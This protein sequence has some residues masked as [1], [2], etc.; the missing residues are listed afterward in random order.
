MT[1]IDPAYPFELGGWTRPV[2]TT[3]PDAQTWFDR[4]LNWLFAYNHEEAVACFGRALDADPGCAM[5]W[6][7]IAYASGPFYNRAWIRFSDA[8]IA[9]TLPVCH[10]AALKAAELWAPGTAAERALIE[11]VALRYQSPSERDRAVLNRWHREFT[12]AMRQVHAAHPDDLDIAALF[13]EAAVT[14]TPRM[15]FDLRTGAPNPASLTVEALAVLET[16]LARCAR[17]GI[18]HPGVLHMHIHALEMSAEP[19]RALASADTLRGLAPDAGHLE[20]MPAH[21]YVLCGGYSEA[22]EQSRR[23]VAAD[24]KYLAVGGETNFYTTARCHDLH[25]YI[26]AAML[27]GQYRT[28]LHAAEKI[29]AIAHRDLLAA[30]APFMR[31]ILDGYSGMRSHVQVR[32]GKWREL[33]REAPPP[34]PDLAPIRT[35][36]FHYA[37]GVA[38]AALGELD[39]AVREADAFHAAR[40]GFAEDAIFLSNTVRD[41][42]GVGAAMLAGEIAYRRGA[43]EEAFDHLRAAVERN[44]ALNYTEPWAW[45]HPPRHALGALLAEQGR[46]EEAEAVYRADLG[47]DPA[48]PRPCRHPDNVWALHGLLECVERRGGTAEAEM[49]RQRL[50]LAQARADFPV[51]AAC[52][53]R[54]KPIAAA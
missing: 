1:E 24:D 29:R 49:L 41:T 28:A 16:A 9:A 43:F 45:M 46:H 37:K 52:C 7:G 32:F 25:L 5:A 17:D 44:D 10:A 35:A 8:E 11:A 40:D 39:A 15:L 13:A 22:V 21:I 2:T 26:Y 38:H 14:C 33:T 27:L 42:L 31:S 34:D 48:V 20:H 12:D 53:C 6:W 30:S 18:T 19:E 54:G 50:T 4:G 23:A 3:S 36:M 51:T 47:L